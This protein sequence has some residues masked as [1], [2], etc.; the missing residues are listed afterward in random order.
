[1]LKYAKSYCT[2]Q[3]HTEIETKRINESKFGIRLR[4]IWEHMEKLLQT[5]SHI[6]NN[7]HSKKI[8][9]K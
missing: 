6:A 4:P 2:M 9:H 5:F 8:K 3:S 7:K 1:M